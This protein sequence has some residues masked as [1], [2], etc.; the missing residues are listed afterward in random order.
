MEA[1]KVIT[2]FDKS[3]TIEREIQSGVAP[4]LMIYDADRSCVYATTPAKAEMEVVDAATFGTI[5]VVELERPAMGVT[6]A[7]DKAYVCAADRPW[8][9]VID[10]NTRKLQARV[11]LSQPGFK[12]VA[13]G[14]K[15]YVATGTEPKP[16]S[17]G[18]TP[19]AAVDVISLRDLRL[20][21]TIKV[22]G[23]HLRAIAGDGQDYVYAA[24]NFAGR[25][26]RIRVAD[27]TMEQGT[28][29]I[30]GRPNDMIIDPVRAIA[31]LSCEGADETFSVVS[32]TRMVEIAC[33]HGGEGFMAV[34]RGAGDTVEHLWVPN[35]NDNQIVSLPAEALE[36]TLNGS[37]K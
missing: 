9:D 4:A 2:V 10:L 24:S 12:S 26:V 15:L 34:Q 16:G 31:V 35:G 30:S 32:L 13:I 1:S 37:R 14:G 5:G 29:E 18:A 8:L 7:S 20:T 3:G 25:L 27:D 23:K 11:Q 28:A 22:P 6:V 19:D 21:K 36:T 17:E 33:F